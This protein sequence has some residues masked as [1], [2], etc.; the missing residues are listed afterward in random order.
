MDELHKQG[1]LTCNDVREMRRH[2]V[3]AQNTRETITTED[4]RQMRKQAKEA[5]TTET[6]KKKTKI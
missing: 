2:F 1:F 5:E 6:K 3:Q 4:I